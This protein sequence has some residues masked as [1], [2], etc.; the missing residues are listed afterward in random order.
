MDRKMKS[1]EEMSMDEILSSIRTLIA[2]DK[3]GGMKSTFTKS[4]EE[5]SNPAGARNLSDI[6]IFDSTD[7]S[8]D[9]SSGLR[10]LPGV[11]ELPSSAFSPL[12]QVVFEPILEDSSLERQ[13]KFSEN[14]R[15]SI[16]GLN[17]DIDIFPKQ[18][19]QQ[20]TKGVIN[21]EKSS[22][23]R[24]IVHSHSSD[25]MDFIQKESPREDVGDSGLD[26]LIERLVMQKVEGILEK[27]IDSVVERVIT[28]KLSVLLSKV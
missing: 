16:E 23:I 13:R 4:V 18:I 24:D 22:S 26:D 15:S 17:E 8:E 5:N 11:D 12:D 9:G 25:P 6:P 28:R 10:P 19:M 27:K 3:G 1:E 7:F 14:L 2:E 21:Q 20:E